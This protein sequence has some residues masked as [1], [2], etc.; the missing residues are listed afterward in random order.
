MKCFDFVVACKV[1]VEAWD[2]LTPENIQKCFSKAGFM[3][4]VEREPESYADPPPRTYGTICSMCLESMF[5][6]L[7]MPLMMTELNRQRGW[8]MQ[9][10]SKQLQVNVKL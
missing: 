7:S 3:P 10:L 6:L 4:Y 5:H 9:P 8:M 1:L 2:A